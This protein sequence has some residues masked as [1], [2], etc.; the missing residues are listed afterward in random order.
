MT[1]QTGPTRS[2]RWWV[3]CTRP[4]CTYYGIGADQKVAQA[5]AAAHDRQ[6]ERRR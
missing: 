2:G 1:C 4:Y 5:M 3:S 6:H